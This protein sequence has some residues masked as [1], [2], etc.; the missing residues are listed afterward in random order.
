M[1]MEF[2]TACP[3]LL[4]VSDYTSGNLSK[5]FF[6]FGFL[7]IFVEKNSCPPN[8]ELNSHDEKAHG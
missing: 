4:A 3:F 6:M 7:K 8:N 2:L 5:S 1:L